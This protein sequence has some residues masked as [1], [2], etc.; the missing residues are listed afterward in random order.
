MSYASY[1]S[2]RRSFF[3]YFIA[4]SFYDTF[5][6]MS[7]ENKGAKNTLFYLKY[8]MVHYLNL[9]DKLKTLAG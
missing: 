9:I 3:K 4:W 6:A 7:L 2:S 8:E 1:V 5:V